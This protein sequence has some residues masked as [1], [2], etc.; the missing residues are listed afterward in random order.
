[1]DIRGSSFFDTS[2]LSIKHITFLLAFFTAFFCYLNASMTL[3][4]RN[5]KNHGKVAY[6]EEMDDFHKKYYYGRR[7]FRRNSDDVANIKFRTNK[8]T[9]I[10]KEQYYTDEILKDFQAGRPVKI[11]YD[12]KDPHNKAIFEKVVR[13]KNINYK[14]AFFYFSLT[15]GLL[16]ATFF[17]KQR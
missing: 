16:L 8:G 4:Y 1:M 11:F 17:P 5:L 14:R 13:S 2:R 10:V 15:M 12:P 3:S 6:I 7:G 9:L